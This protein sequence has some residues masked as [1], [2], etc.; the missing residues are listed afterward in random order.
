MNKLV[1][2]NPKLSNPNLGIN[3]LL[4]NLKVKLTTNPWSFMFRIR[5]WPFKTTRKPLS[6]I[7]CVEICKI[8]LGQN[9]DQDNFRVCKCNEM[10]VTHHNSQTDQSYV[11]PA[12]QMRREN[13]KALRILTQHFANLDYT[14]R[15]QS[16]M[17]SDWNANLVQHKSKGRPRANNTINL[18]RCRNSLSG[19]LNNEAK[20]LAYFCSAMFLYSVSQALETWIWTASAEK[21]GYIAWIFITPR[22]FNDRV[23]PIKFCHIVAWALKRESID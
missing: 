10:N 6:S 17:S 20:T 22:R 18:Q 4:A 12:M 1:S 16:S 14:I 13:R 23:T 9:I 5:F 8:M 15:T 7:N 21:G 19:L 11:C 2:C 3:K